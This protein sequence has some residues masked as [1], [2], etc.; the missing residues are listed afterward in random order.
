MGK[1]LLVADDSLTIQKVIRLALSNEG[2]DIQAVSNGADAVEQIGLF[3][4]DVVLIDISLPSRSAFEV[5]RAVNELSHLAHTRFVLMSSAFEKV[6]ETQVN[7]VGFHGRLTKPFD[8]AHLRQVLNGVLAESGPSAPIRAKAPVAQAPTAPSHTPA[9]PREIL[10]DDDFGPPAIS[11]ESEP[12]Y[13]PAPGPNDSLSGDELWEREME[14]A[15]SGPPPTPASK[16]SVPMQGFLSTEPA[17]SIS[18]MDDDFGSSA[19]SGSGE[20]IRHL[21]ESTIRL[22]GLDD[23]QWSVKE[24]P[25]RTSAP[26]GP[27]PS[28]PIDEAPVPRE[29]PRSAPRLTP[30]QA[31]AAP[32][33]MQSAPIQAPPQTP[34]SAGSA[35]I[36]AIVRRQVEQQLEKMARD[37]LPQIAERVIKAEIH[38]LLTEQP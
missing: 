2:Y 32:S 20:D 34:S 26:E 11:L 28:F 13:K 35:D 33:S 37:L 3:Q 12:S 36:E 7:E 24:P 5:K 23:F 27:P 21:T 19:E 14:V 10:I 9:I 15:N 8:P 25:L 22:S 6:D 1:K 29:M 4:P 17:V 30:V 31:S 38:K 18:G 16:A